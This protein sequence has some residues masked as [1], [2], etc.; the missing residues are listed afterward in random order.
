M[1]QRL[2][3]HISFSTQLILDFLFPKDPLTESLE[4]LSDEDLQPLLGNPEPTE[5]IK[6]MLVLYDFKSPQTKHLIHQIKFNGNKK[7]A[8][9]ASQH[10]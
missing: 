10:L 2:K 7:L 8:G 4:T 1:M 5:E 3:N 6:D 9:K